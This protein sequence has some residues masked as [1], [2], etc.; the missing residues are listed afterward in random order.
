MTLRTALTT[1]ILATAALAALCRAEPPFVADVRWSALPEKAGP[2]VDLS[3][4]KAIALPRLPSAP[5]LDGKLDDQAW[6]KAAE[7]DAWMINTGQGRAP[8]Q[9][10][11][12]FGVFDGRLFVG[13]KADEPNMAGVAAS[14]TKDGGPVWN[15]DCIELFV[16]NNLDLTTARQLVINSKGVVTGLLRGTDWRPT[17]ER[18]AGTA[19]NAWILE[20]ALPLTDL[21]LT[22]TEFGLN[23][24]RERR[25]GGGN[26]LSCWAPTGGGFLQPGKYALATLQGGCLRAFR[27]GTGMLGRNELH[28]TIGNPDGQP[29]TMTATLTWQQGEAPPVV[30]KAG[31]H[32]LQPGQ[33]RDIT[34][35]YDIHKAALP[36]RVE[37]AVVDEKGNALARQQTT[38]GV[39]DVLDAA[40][41][42]RVLSPRDRNMAVRALVRVSDDVL[43]RSLITIAL[44]DANG[45]LKARQELRPEDKAMRAEL[46]VPEL[47]PGHYT[48]RL[49]LNSTHTTPPQRVAEETAPLRI[50]PAVP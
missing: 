26:Q 45:A 22:G 31:P 44:L 3:V 23:I 32:K 1:A 9:S 27:V 35:S 49:A 16:D 30:R 37:L 46:T 29:R 21:D 39:V 28:V 2:E 10:K 4:R 11:A 41:S 48:I 38:Q 7:T 13:V 17:V 42:R 25:A 5:N 36:A 20:F 15:D 33:S 8:V 50:L 34:F 14:V 47:P 19:P 43:R 24:C 40:V 12:W 6:R 18:A